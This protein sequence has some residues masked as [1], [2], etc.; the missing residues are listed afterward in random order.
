V[1]YLSI[2]KKF[3]LNQ[4]AGNIS[5]WHDVPYQEALDRHRGDL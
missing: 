5:R 3:L 4:Q 1:R 2:W